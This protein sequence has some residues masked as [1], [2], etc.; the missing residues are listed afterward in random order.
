MRSYLQRVPLLLASAALVAAIAAAYVSPATADTTTA[1]KPATNIEA[2]ID[3]SG[4]MLGTDPDENRVAAIKLLISKSG[5][6]NKTLGAVEFGSDQSYLTPPVPAAVTLF[7]P[8]K[9]GTNAGSMKNALGAV[10]GDNGATDYNAAF[11]LAK[12][13]NP[14]A[15]ARIFITD[16]GHNMGDYTNGHVPGPPTYVIGLD[17]K[18]VA[19]FDPAAE[20]RLKQIAA[21]TGGVYYPDVDKNNIQATVNKIDAALNCQT[22]AK[23]F[24]DTF[25]K[26]GQTKSK[27]V[28]VGSSAKAVDLTLTWPSPLDTFTVSG[29]K[30]KTSSGSTISIAKKRLKIKRTA[31]KTYL[32]LHITGVKRGKLLFKLKSKVLKSGTGGVKL[33]TQAVPSKRR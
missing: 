19:S 27:I 14:T 1:C 2:I 21:D 9:I 20:P 5:N 10:K 24:T 11:A 33:T 31:G 28:S 25:T 13:D 16:G 32:N 29:L 26:Q 30:L 12:S 18:A 7:K 15:D 6:A 22:V 23:T 3:D 17:I 4:S 8:E